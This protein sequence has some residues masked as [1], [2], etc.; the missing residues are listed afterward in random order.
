MSRRRDRGRW[1]AARAAAIAAS[2]AAAIGGL[3]V[4]C[5]A[6]AAGPTRLPP[7]R[8]ARA[9][10]DAAGAPAV[11]G[12]RAREF[13]TAGGLVVPYRLYAPPEARGRRRVPLVLYLHGGSGRGNDNL[14]QIRGGNELPTHVWTERRTR[15]RNPVFVLAPQIPES[16]HWEGRDLEN[17]SPYAAA[18][19]DLVAALERELPIDPHRI[20]LTGQSLGGFGVWDIAAKKPRLFAAA[21]PMCGGG[22][23]GLAASLRSVPI[24]AFHGARDE[25]VPVTRT[26]E[27]VAAVRAAGG[28]VRYTE[29]DDVDH[30]VWTRAYRDKRLSEWLFAQSREKKRSPAATKAAMSK[31]P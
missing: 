3:A 15:R 31:R 29:Y 1:R 9:A 17:L 11:D 27:M 2:L 24:W 13:R 8:P 23:P 28:N 5:V 20:Y 30:L 7:V 19:L 22:R 16:E 14:R 18:V 26:R 12:F 25:A 21:V 4:P 10:A 6:A